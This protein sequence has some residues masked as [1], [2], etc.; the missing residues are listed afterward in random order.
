[1]IPI[2]VTWQPVSR[3][4]SLV[5]GMWVDTVSMPNKSYTDGTWEH[6]AVIVSFELNTVHIVS[7]ANI[8]TVEGGS[9]WE[10]DPAEEPSQR[11]INLYGRRVVTR[12]PDNDSQA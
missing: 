4:A 6:R 5:R 8:R 9:W 12:R 11:P 2:E 1:M 10:E 7:V 3:N